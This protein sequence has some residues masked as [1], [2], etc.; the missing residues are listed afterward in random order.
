[1]DLTLTEIQ[2][3]LQNSTREF[4]EA[5]MPKS[6]VL[7]IDDSESGFASDIWQQIAELGYAGMLIPEEYGG[8]GNSY[9]DMGVVYEM[10]GYYACP[11]PHHSSAVLAAHA[12][13][14]AGNSEQKDSML[15]AIASGQQIF[16]FAYT[17]PDYGWGSRRGAASGYEAGR[18]LRAQRDQAFHSRRQ[19]V[20][21]DDSR[22]AAPPRAPA[23]TASACS[24][25]TA[26]PPACPSASRPA[27]SAQ[28]CAR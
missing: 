14:E 28:R 1:M 11:S 22:G 12:I 15:P 10:M 13:L 21:P 4:L 17:E 6:R 19:R 7:E 5:E 27:G 8:S 9:T 3:L 26:T 18:R 25:W 20:R 2:N 24:W 16:A 23:R